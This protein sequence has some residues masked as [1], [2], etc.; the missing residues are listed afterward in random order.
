MDLHGKTVDRLI[1]IN[2]ADATL[3]MHV[4][5]VGEIVDV[6]A[7]EGVLDEKGYPDA[8]KV[9]PLI[10]TPVTRAYHTVGRYIGQAFEIGRSFGE[11]S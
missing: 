5:F 4:Q 6:K 2:F 11:T 1:W 9:C 10:F 3:G 8:V 7:E